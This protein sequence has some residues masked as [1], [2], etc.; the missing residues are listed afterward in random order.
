MQTRH[1]LTHKH[2]EKVFGFG[3]EHSPVDFERVFAAANLKVS[4]F[5][6]AQQPG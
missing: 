2:L 5:R 1:H 4:K 3:N 6:R